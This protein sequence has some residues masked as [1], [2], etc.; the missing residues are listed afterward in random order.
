MH[1]DSMFWF[2]STT[3]YDPLSSF[4]HHSKSVYHIRMKNS[5]SKR[6][7]VLKFTEQHLGMEIIKVFPFI[8]LHFRKRTNKHTCIHTLKLNW[9]IGFCVCSW[10]YSKRVFVH[11]MNL[12]SIRL[13]NNWHD[14]Q[15]SWFLFE[16]K[17]PKKKY[18]QISQSVI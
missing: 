1:Q 3:P 6:K 11:Q 4:I 12:P 15:I 9:K 5:C 2:E 13:K 8:P 18:I 7:W 10:A 17:T 14:W 16:H